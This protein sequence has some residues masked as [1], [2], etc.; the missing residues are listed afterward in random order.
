M[1]HKISLE[2]QHIFIMQRLSDWKLDICRY[3][4][5]YTLRNKDKS[6]E[7]QHLLDAYFTQPPQHLDRL[8][9]DQ[10][11]FVFL[12]LYSFVNEAGTVRDQVEMMEEPEDE[13]EEEEEATVSN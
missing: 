2:Q 5:H 3:A 4:L 13:E 12:A 11:E 10:L 9:Q 7:A 6:T 8:T 1:K